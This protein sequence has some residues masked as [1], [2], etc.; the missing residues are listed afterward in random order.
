MEK[1]VL[2]DDLADKTIDL[3]CELEITDRIKTL[4]KLHT[5]RLVAAY[6]ELSGSERFSPSS[7]KDIVLS[8]QKQ[9]ESGELSRDVFNYLR[10]IA[11]DLAEVA[12]SGTLSHETKLTK[13]P[14]PQKRLES[15]QA[16]GAELDTDNV[17][18]LSV[19]ALSMME[20]SGY[21]VSTIRTFKY[22]AFPRVINFFLEHGTTQ[23]SDEMI[24]R[25]IEDARESESELC[26]RTR[27]QVCTAA[28]H[29]RS[30]HNSG[31]LSTIKDSKD[32]QVMQA[33]RTWLGPILAE[34]EKWRTDAGIKP[35]SIKV[36]LHYIVSF[37]NALSLKEPGDLSNLTREQVRGARAALSEGKSPRY[38]IGMLSPVRN[39]ARFFEACHPEY[40]QFRQWIGPNPR[41]VKR[42]PIEGYSQDHASAIIDSIDVTTETGMRDLAIVK[43]LQ[44]TGMRAVDV[45]ALRLEDIDWHANEISVVQEKT[46]VPIA[47]PLDTETG[48]ALATYILEARRESDSP[49]VFLTAIGKA[50]PLSA[51][52]VS[53]IAEKHGVKVSSQGFAGKHGSHAFRR[54]LGAAL[55]GA[56]VPLSD[57][58]DML[59]QASALSA[60]PY[61]ALD[62]ERLRSCCAGLASVPAKRKGA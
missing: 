5:K 23:Y 47:M 20:N 56:G 43:L 33:K 28:R 8:Y 48:E 25:A 21:A 42:R 7:L 4:Y 52:T 18:V 32:S 22:S 61:V 26:S 45:A 24:D 30:V 60:M 11:A 37:L 50:R 10:R 53:S 58:A 16:A 34:Y 44:T 57:I 3:I 51:S 6:K 29:I 15:T 31:A 59:G 38:V 36:D 35:S 1:P 2:I 13:W 54:G 41:A 40:T 55:A 49:V 46:G 19:M 12:D 62:T 27:S 39:F 9:L 14:M 17:M